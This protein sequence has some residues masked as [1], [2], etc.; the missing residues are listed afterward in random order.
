[1]VTPTVRGSDGPGAASSFRR[2]LAAGDLVV[3]VTMTFA[4]PALA[5]F[6]GGLG[7]GAVVLDGEHG[8]ITD[9]DVE[10]IVLACDL[11]GCAAVLRIDAEPALLERYA[12]LGVTGFQIPRTRS[13]AHIRAVIDAVKFAPIGRRG[14]GSS[15]MTG[16]GLLGGSIPELTARE[17][18]RIAVLVQ[19]ED[20]EGLAVL[21]EIVRIPE[22]DAVLVGALD[23]SADLGLPGEVRNAEVVAMVERIVR[24]ATEAGKPV[25]LG[26]PSIEAAQSAV[27]QGARYLLTSDV[28]LLSGGARGL[29]QAMSP[30]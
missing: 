4:H 24:L 20:R 18:D 27:A 11:V 30:T 28:R 16:Y 19:I 17:N 29:L 3:A 13:A 21:P 12:N 8:A 7:F 5:E 10:A 9:R 26:A 14:L 23:I 15:R 25:G 22:V 2:R 1:M 6:L